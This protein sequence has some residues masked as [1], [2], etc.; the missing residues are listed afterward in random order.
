M[1]CRTPSFA[2]MVNGREPLGT[3]GGI[4]KALAEELFA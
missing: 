1:T 3:S 4:L 2:F